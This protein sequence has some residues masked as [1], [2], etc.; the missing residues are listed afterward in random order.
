[1]TPDRAAKLAH[2]RR[3]LIAQGVPADT[4]DVFLAHNEANPEIGLAFKKFAFEAIKKG[5]RIGA[6][7]IMERVRWEAE[8]EGGKDWKCNNNFTAYYA[9][10][11]VICFPQYSDFFEFRRVTGLESEK[12]AN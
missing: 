4:V 10:L 8:V 11:F 5:K 7:A 3:S 2:Y 9:R 1:M 6:K 12:Y